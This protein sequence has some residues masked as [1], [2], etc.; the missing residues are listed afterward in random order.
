MDPTDTAIIARLYESLIDPRRRA[1]FQ[2]DMDRLSQRRGGNSDGEPTMLDSR[3]NLAIYAAIAS[4]IKDQFESLEKRCELWSI[5][6]ASI[7]TM[8]MLVDSDLSL[9]TCSGAGKR[10]LDD[11]D[12]LVV[13]NGKLVASQHDYTVELRNCVKAMSS[14]RSRRPRLMSIPREGGGQLLLSFVPL[15]TSGTDTENVTLVQAVDPGK[16]TRLDSD[17][18]SRLYGMTKAEAALAC[19][20][21]AGATLDQAAQKLSV[22]S[23]TIKTHLKRIF[24][25]TNTTRQSELVSLLLKIATIC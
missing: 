18:L 15:N 22:S 7:P 9:K 5:V 24:Q 25:K 6:F 23:N 19:E 12:G 11:R 16:S 4:R 8:A 2:R 20:I 14:N 3:S 13:V 21:A 10:L 17:T 1:D